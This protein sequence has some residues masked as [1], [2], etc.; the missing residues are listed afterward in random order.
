V[1]QELGRE[2]ET[3]GPRYGIRLNAQRGECGSIAQRGNDGP[4]I[5]KDRFAQVDLAL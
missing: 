2:V 3:V 1:E 4:V 5:R